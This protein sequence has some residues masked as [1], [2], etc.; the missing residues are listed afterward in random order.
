VRGLSGDPT[1]LTQ[2]KVGAVLGMS[3]RG[4]RETESASLLQTAT[5]QRCGKCGM[6]VGAFGL[7]RKRR[8]T[9]LKTMSEIVFLLLGQYA[10]GMADQ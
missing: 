7:A 9:C 3:A 2:K 10:N 6:I 8:I 5:I 1:V 4:I